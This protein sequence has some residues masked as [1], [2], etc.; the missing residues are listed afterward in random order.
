[1]IALRIRKASSSKYWTG[2]LAA[3]LFAV[4]TA[5]AQ[6]KPAKPKPAATAKPATPAKPAGPAG[7]GAARGPSTSTAGRGATTTTAGRGTTT[8][9]RGAAGGGATTAGRSGAAG[10]AGARGGGASTAG[11]GAAGG[12]AATAGRSG[13]P[14]AGGARGGAPGGARGGAGRPGEARA[15]GAGGRGSPRGP[16][17][18]APRGSTMARTRGGDEVR[19]RADGRPGDVHVA[20]RGMDIHHGLGGGRRVEVERADHSRIVAERGG[21]GYVQHPYMYRGHE[22]AHRTYY[23]HGR[24]YDRF[25]ARYPYHGVYVEMYTPAVYYPPAYYG[26]A[27]NPWAV[28]VAYPVAAWGWGGSPWYGYYGAYFTPYPVYPSASVWLTDYLISTTLSAAYQARAGAAAAAQAQVAAAGAAALNPQVKDMIAAEVQRQIAIENAEA[29]QQGAGPNPAVSG[30]Q[31]M[32]SDNIPHVFVAGR[33]LDVV[34]ANGTECAISEGDVLQLTPTPLPADATAATLVVLASK[35]GVECRKGG[36]VTVGIVDLQDMQNRMR[37]SIGQ[38]MG[39]LRAKQ[40]QGGL[41]AI[42][43]S[44]AAATV[45]ASFATEAPPPDP[46]A[47]AQIA[48]QAQEADKA[49]REVLAQAAP[50]GEAV[51]AGGAPP[52]A[53][54]PATISLGQSVDEVTSALGQPKNVINLGAKKIYIYKDMKITFNSGKV[55]DVQ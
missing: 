54:P 50:D 19:R 11:R 44:A 16:D 55:T 3:L 32:L 2:T 42:P 7:G 20:G 37:E 49:E 23:E 48:Q 13:T 12:G 41:P 35:G 53:G 38:G 51:P 28:P 8:A 43:A 18:R 4:C 40:G 9:G 14:G 22:Y 39:D 1:M 36:A 30:I 45:K 47:A 27:Y 24:A 6:E 29:A 34:D 10:A 25:Y 21:H 17:G 5:Q 46:D 31:R 26:W 52:P 33:E 15:G